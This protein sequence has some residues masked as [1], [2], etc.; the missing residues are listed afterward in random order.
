MASKSFCIHGH[1]Y[2]PPR[3][4]PITGIIPTEPGASPYKNWNERINAEC[5]RP[6]AELG[7]FERLSFNVGPTL[8][9]WL[10]AKDP[11]TYRRILAQDQATYQRYG[12]GNAIAQAYNHTILPLASSADKAI[13]IS[14]G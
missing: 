5:Y 13:Q 8:F 12:V 7:N 2:Q 1:F 4:D 14:W 11:D 6:N 9:G 3:E 10:E